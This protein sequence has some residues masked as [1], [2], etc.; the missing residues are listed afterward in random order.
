MSD[1]ANYIE[2]IVIAGKVALSLFVIGGLL[3]AL[4]YL[5]FEDRES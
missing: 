4:Y 1:Y 3:K 5:C 2:F